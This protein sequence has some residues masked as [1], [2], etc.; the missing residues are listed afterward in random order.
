M[1]RYLAVLALAAGAGAVEAAP[2]ASSP[3]GV[4][5][6][7]AGPHR[8]LY[9]RA[10]ARPDGPP[11]GV[12]RYTPESPD[13]E[14]HALGYEYAFSRRAFLRARYVQV[15]NRSTAACNFG[16]DT[17]PLAPGQDPRGVSL[18]MRLVF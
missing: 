2:P 18:G 3:S 14:A 15:T 16:F 6:V 7:A 5:L 9:E 17:L 8:L 1:K 11:R 12:L 4:A 10:A 13:C